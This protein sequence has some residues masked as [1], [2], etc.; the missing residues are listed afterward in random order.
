MPKVT[1]EVTVKTFASLEARENNQ[2]IRTLGTA[3]D[4]EEFQDI[5]RGCQ[6]KEFLGYFIMKGIHEIPLDRHKALLS[7]GATY[8][9]GIPDGDNIFDIE[10]T[11]RWRGKLL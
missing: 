7:L 10:G 1:E 9:Q 8:Y 2:P 3:K 11:Y 6:K 5:C 4:P